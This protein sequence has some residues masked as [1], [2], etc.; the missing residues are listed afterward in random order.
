MSRVEDSQRQAQIEAERA[1]K[2]ADRQAREAKKGQ[3]AK[4]FGK[5]VRQGALKE[6]A[7]QAQKAKAAEARELGQKVLAQAQ[8]QEGEAARTAL[9]ARGGVVQ[10]QRILEQVKSFQGTLQSQRAEA[11]QAHAAR[12][13]RRE[14]G[15]SEA[16]AHTEERVTDLEH[17]REARAERE[18]EAQKAEAKEKARVNA[19]IDGDA[20]KKGGS[21]TGEKGAAADAMPAQAVGAKAQG[22]AEAQAPREVKQ[23]P[24]AIL[25]ALAEQVYVGVNEKGQAEFRVELKEGVLSG[26]TLKVTADGKGKIRLAF[27]GLDANARRLV[28]ASEGELARKLG[29]KGLSLEELKV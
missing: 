23:I 16:K 26:A 7:A 13:E 25:N 22:A 17:K 21:D 3:E 27:E 20:G 14:E 24:E 9:L 8:K 18:K 1:Q 2:Q 28:Q 5:L 10:H 19:A 4:Q 6:Q 29:A 15:L 11:E 12:V